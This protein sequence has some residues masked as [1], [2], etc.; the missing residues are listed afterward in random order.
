MRKVLGFTRL[1]IFV[2]ASA[3]GLLAWLGWSYTGGGLGVNPVQAATQWA[4][5]FALIYLLFSLACMPLNAL[6]GF[7]QALKVRRALGLYAFMFA[8]VHL[9]I[10]VGLDYVFDWT[11]LWLDV[12]NKRYV[13]V[14]AGAMLILLAL[15]VTSFRWWMKRLGKNWK[16]LH[17]LVYLAGML[18]VV[19]YAW[20]K[21]GDLFRLQGDI[22]GPLVAGVILLVLLAVRIPALRKAV[23]AMRSRLKKRI[24]PGSFRAQAQS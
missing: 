4:G 7:R 18:V 15:A 23:R 6:F 10:F 12:A 22:L 11:L 20:A 19:H 2:H 13:F 16:R 21:K 8:A 17:R 24:L 14:G 1:Q 9:G 5:R 3:W